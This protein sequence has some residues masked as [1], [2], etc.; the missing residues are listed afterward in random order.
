MKKV[1]SLRFEY[2]L[3]AK[4][5]LFGECTPEESPVYLAASEAFARD[6][7]CTAMR[8]WAI[9]DDGK[10]SISLAWWPRHGWKNN[11]IYRRK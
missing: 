6:N 1:L 3:R 10:E 2:L 7:A 9:T 5:Q 11:D 4:W 8:M